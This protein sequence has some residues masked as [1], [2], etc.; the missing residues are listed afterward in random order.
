M[1]TQSPRHPN[2]L[3]AWLAGS[4]RKLTQPRRDL[5]VVAFY[6][7]IAVVFTWP[8]VLHFSQSAPGEPGG[9]TWQMVWNLWWVRQALEH[10][11]NPFQTNLIFYPQ[12]TGLYLH[13]LNPLN[14]LVSLPVQLIVGAFST[15]AA[16]AIAGYNFIVL[17]SFSLAA[18]GAFCLARY[19]W[20]AEKAALLA[21]LAYG[22]STY[23][24]DHLLGHLNLVSYELI[25]FYIL[26]FLKT[27][28][29]NCH[30]VSLPSLKLALPAVL[31]L[32]GLTLL[33]L[34]Y[35]L[36][37]G[38]FSLFYLL[39]LIG[40]A[41]WKKFRQKP[42]PF[43]LGW[44]YLRGL[45]IGVGF[46]ILSLPLTIPML[47]EALNNP[48]TVPLRQEN[49]Y[50][51]DL[52]AYFYPSPFHPWWGAAMQRAIKPFTATLIEKV[53]F[54]GFTV[55]LLI[56]AGF[57]WWLWQRFVFSRRLTA[58]P[59]A[60]I[61]E[62]ATA[63]PDETGPAF[64]PGPL[65]W[66]VIAAAFAVLSFGPRL[67]INGLEYGPDLP[68]ALIYEIPIL[69]ITRVPA[70]FGIVAILGLALV[71]AWG[72]SRLAK[73][74]Q[75]KRRA[76]NALTVLALLILGFELLPAPY[77]L[78]EYKVSSFYQT[79]AQQPAGDYSI[80][81]IPLNYGKYQYRTDYLE[82]QMTHAKAILNGYISRNPVFP[83]YYG[84]PVFLEFRDFNTSPRPDILPAQKPDAGVLR[85]FGVRY[86]V[87]R[88]D[89]IQGQELANAFEMVSQVLPGQP[90]VYDSPD[91]TAYEVPSGPKAGFFYNL[92]LP[93]WYEAEKGPDGHYSRWVQG[94]Q[95]QLDFWTIEPRQL[96]I[97]FPAWSFQQ[98]LAV[99]FRL[100]DRVIGQAQVT[101]EPQTIRLTLALQ[102]GQN[103][104]DFKISGQGLR[105]ADVSGGPDTRSLTINTG[106]ISFSS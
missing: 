70:R 5:A 103:R 46:I 53:V 105:P 26:F 59:R 52:L 75:G 31:F 74:L 88:K 60:G 34:Q 21:G 89:I 27:L 11:Q 47:R 81:E 35:V 48:N 37:M 65:F 97:S 54:P 23:G 104:L 19:L 106:E 38:F 14:G 99:E 40:L 84:L 32:L 20:G 56:L 94:N 50:S 90:P 79:L 57:G 44:I 4:G 51:A 7:V 76:Y 13:A 17:L 62:A 102:P 87:I 95:G 12:G 73:L 41:L 8:L 63:A 39:Y 22:F 36:Y 66:L 28:H 24:F 2:R 67:H 58:P 85:Y 9:D 71:A 77:P 61:S 96:E 68:G 93:A 29:N 100:N 98:A 3:P 80:M 33:E 6:A 83:P 42:V 55:Y 72:L 30:P 78:V 91:L 43:R 10:F 45:T 64:R 25:P 49:V 101:P 69:N 82:A 86:I 92:V 16:G 18:Y 15:S 1:I